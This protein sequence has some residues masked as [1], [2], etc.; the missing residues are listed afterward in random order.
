MRIEKTATQSRSTSQSS[1]DSPS[2]LPRHRPHRPP[3]TMNFH[4]E[5]H[6]ARTSKRSASYVGR[7][8]ISIGTI[9]RFSLYSIQLLFFYFRQDSV[10]VRFKSFAISSVP[11][12]PPH[13]SINLKLYPKGPTPRTH[14]SHVSSSKTTRYSQSHPFIV[15]PHQSASEPSRSHFYRRR[16]TSPVSSSCK[17]RPPTCP[18]PSLH[19]PLS[20]PPTPPSPH[21]SRHSSAPALTP[22]RADL[23]PTPHPAAPQRSCL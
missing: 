6:R 19:P 3:S 15:R 10:V 13:L 16:C 12:A 2:I 21:P 17:R 4:P 20:R 7:Q 18:H 23:P 5:R 1:A 8:G 14:K 11:L 22:S 9:P